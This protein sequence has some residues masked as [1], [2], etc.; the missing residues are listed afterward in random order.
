MVGVEALLVGKGQ[1]AR[2]ETRGRGG[3]EGRRCVANALGGDIVVGVIADGATDHAVAFNSDARVPKN[4]AKELQDW[5]RVRLWPPEVASTVQLR[6]LKGPDGQAFAVV[7]VPPWP[8][9]RVAVR[10]TEPPGRF[11]FPCRRDAG[12]V[13]LELE[14]FMLLERDRRAYLNLAEL[15]TRTTGHVYIASSAQ[16]DLG[17][18]RSAVLR[19]RVAHGRVTEVTAPATQLEMDHGAVQEA[20]ND[21]ARRVGRHRFQA[22]HGRAPELGPH[23]TLDEFVAEA[24]VELRTEFPDRDRGRM[25]IIPNSLVRAVWAVEGTGAPIHVVLDV[26]V[27]FSGRRWVLRTN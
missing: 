8:N 22:V 7:T 19:P 26:V 12:T 17:A 9:G 24:F 3:R 25:L 11:F 2:K 13:F 27:I 4:A 16:V 21:V 1:Q 14:E 15:K 6:R 5:L 18:G 23:S 10:A 20:F